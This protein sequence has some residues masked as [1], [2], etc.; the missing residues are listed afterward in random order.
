MNYPEYQQF[1]KERLNKTLFDA[2]F[3]GELDKIKYLLTS[4]DL[5]MKADL[6][7][8]NY[9]VF[10]T[11][12][13]RGHMDIVRYFLTSPELKDHPKI[14]VQ[15][16][17]GLMRAAITGNLDLVKYLLTSPDLK[18]HAN[19]H[20]QKGQVLIEA[21][22]VDNATVLQYLLT[23]PEWKGKLDIHMQDDY[24][25]KIA[26]GTGKFEVLR[27]L[28]SSPD[29]TDKVNPK[30]LTE[31]ELVY[32]VQSYF[33][34]DPEQRELIEYALYDLGIKITPQMVKK[35][36]KNTTHA[37]FPHQQEFLKMVE[38]REM[39]VKMNN[40]LKDSKKS[41]ISKI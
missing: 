14:N 29:L 23:S 28:L 36:N 13:L 25:A 34:N 30:V 35:M 3:I 12:C 24:G 15:K 17:E 33:R 16:S 27:Y 18:E 9:G 32:F 8:D 37:N 11:A 2:C 4:P 21:C 19:I 26:L 10:L 20:A 39:F 40:D 38:K 6:K 5:K 22:K 31:I 41:R 7:H 1:S